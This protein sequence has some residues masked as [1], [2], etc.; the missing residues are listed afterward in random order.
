MASIKNKTR[1]VDWANIEGDVLRCIADMTD[2]AQDLVR[3]TAV[4]RSWQAIL[5]NKRIKFPI[6]L[7]LTEGYYSNE[8]CFYCLLEAIFDVLYLPE[9]Q[10]RR[11][12]GSPFGWL[13]IYALD[14]E[15]RL[16]NP[17]SRT[18]IPLPSLSTI[19]EEECCSRPG[20]LFEYSSDKLILCTSPEESDCI[21][22]ANTSDGLFFAK[23][24][25]EAWTLI[26]HG[27]RH[28]LDDAIYFKGNFYGCLHTGE[29]VLCEATHP[30][31]VEFA[32]PPPDL[33]YF[34][35]GDKAWTAID[36]HDPRHPL[37]DA[38]NFKGNFYGC[39]GNEDWPSE[40]LFDY[41]KRKLILC[42]SPEESDCIVLATI[43][44]G[45]FF[46]KPSDEA[47]TLIC[48]G[49]RHQLDDA[50]YFKGNFYGCLHT[51]KIVLCEATHP[52][53]VEFAPSPD[54][55]EFIST[56]TYLLDLDGNLCIGCRHTHSY[57]FTVG[58]DIFKLDID[59]KTWEKI[60][61]LG[62]RSLLLGNCSTFA[63]AAAD[64][65][66]CKPNCIYY[67]VDSPLLAA[68][69][70]ID[71]GIYDCQNMT[72]EKDRGFRARMKLFPKSKDCDEVLL[73]FLSPL[74]I[75]PFPYHH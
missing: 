53:V 29:I 67:S 46:A 44:A 60:Y 38:N 48:H 45:S 50:I 75:V 49:D 69:P 73:Y 7:M 33:R 65:P 43:S 3:M 19:A 30:K 10:G 41:S 68:T 4:C 37:N 71:L 14:S 70:Y 25:D 8:H 55:P 39:L 42:T 72:L 23:P 36:V 6:C 52:K 13:V 11:C 2:V 35:P 12:W 15:T 59:T 40:D 63:I 18:R 28:H 62:D 56:V 51:G 5:A 22:L 57:A 17:F 1:F 20:E 26:C 58:F 31:V 34:Y 24:S 47:W 74:W 64:Y 16:F 32:P 54:L 27:D 66:G 9:I 61:S 21:V